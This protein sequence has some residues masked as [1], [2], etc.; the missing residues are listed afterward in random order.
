MNN[1]RFVEFVEFNESEGEVFVTFV[2]ITDDNKETLER[3]IQLGKKAEFPYDELEIRASDP[4]VDEDSIALMS[5][6]DMNDYMPKFVIS[7]LSDNVV[8][9]LDEF[10]SIEDDEELGTELVDAFYK[11]LGFA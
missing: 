9:R 7:Q 8:S 6:Y 5:L 4:R 11:R 10:E 1:S 3:F 2:E